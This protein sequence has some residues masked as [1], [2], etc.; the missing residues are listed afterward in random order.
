MTS[1]PVWV[2]ACSGL[3]G[4]LNMMGLLF[5]GNMSRLAGPKLEIGAEI[6]AAANTK[7]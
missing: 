6:A 3:L 2:V 7:T 4:Y 1:V 5:F